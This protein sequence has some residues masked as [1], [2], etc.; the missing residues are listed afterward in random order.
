MFYSFVVYAI[1]S[2]LP[3]AYLYFYPT[4]PKTHPIRKFIVSAISISSFILLTHYLSDP[5]QLQYWFALIPLFF[6]GLYAG[7]PYIVALAVI[8]TCFHLL[9]YTTNSEFLLFITYLL[10][11]TTI[12]VLVYTKYH[13]KPAIGKLKILL[14]S[15]TIAGL[16]C[17][18]IFLQSELAAVIEHVKY[19]LW[20]QIIYFAIYYF[21][22]LFSFLV[23][24]RQRD[25]EHL[26]HIYQSL[27]NTY[28]YELN[29]WIQV[30]RN[31]PFAVVSINSNEEII[32]ANDKAYVK[33][34]N[35]QHNQ[36]NKLIQGQNLSSILTSAA[37]DPV[38][39]LVQSVFENKVTG[40]INEYNGDKCYLYSALP[41]LSNNDQKIL[42]VALFIQDVTE[43]HTL[44]NEIDRM[45]RL[46]LV[47]QM[48][49]SVTHEI[50]NPMAVIRGFVQLVQ[51]KSSS[52]QH[53][54][55]RI[56]IGELD[57]ANEIISDFLALAQQ[58]EVKK[59]LQ[60]INS[61]IE[62]LAPLLIADANLRGQRIEFLLEEHLP[63]LLL[64]EHEI[65]QLLLNIVRN[66]MEAMDANGYLQISTSYNCD[67]IVLSVMDEGP[68]IPDE[69]KCKVFEPFYSSKSVGTGLGLPLCADIAKR[70][71]AHIEILDNKDNGSI[72]QISFQL[73]QTT[74]KP[75]EVQLLSS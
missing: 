52:I 10:V 22:L 57:R 18:L 67:V 35:L 27:E 24:I 25:N 13:S 3:A 40:N 30:I 46:S 41:I 63:Q 65:K 38:S 50:R 31:A 17:T 44:R 34:A 47:G 49:A 7:K 33:H 53:E 69:L 72:F 48:A 51:E 59:E 75:L 70:H 71:N 73:K 4:S 45:D 32:Y 58:R 74:E 42:A 23:L 8:V 28:R 39:Q 29:T 66:A 9:F 26:I 56:I 64:N 54:Y 55:Y 2:V 11:V 1:I 36:N 16:I 12:N 62:E 21:T 15:V 61:I 14:G 20:E 37:Y 6:T 43:L 68:G 60:H 5:Y 19:V